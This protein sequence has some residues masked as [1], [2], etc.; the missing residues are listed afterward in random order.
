VAEPKNLAKP[1]SGAQGPLPRPVPAGLLDIS[2]RQPF[3]ALDGTR[4]TSGDA[5]AVLAIRLRVRT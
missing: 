3:A 4:E 1:A 2:S 5:D